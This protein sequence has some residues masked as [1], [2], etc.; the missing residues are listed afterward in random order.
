VVIS[1]TTIHY[2]KVGKPDILVL[3]SQG[4][5]TTYGGSICPDGMMIIDADLVHI[6]GEPE[7]VSVYRVPFTRMAERLGK[8]IVA[9][10][11]MLGAL[12]ALGRVT[13][14]ES[15]KQSVLS[16]I[17]RGTEELNIAAFDQGYEF[18]RSLIE[19]GSPPEEE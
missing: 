8:T 14:Y 1:D 12:A 9:N 16:S 2:P 18:G 17:P 19:R 5:F 6:D 10:I 13:S 7:G 15:M 3:M 11:V 4:A